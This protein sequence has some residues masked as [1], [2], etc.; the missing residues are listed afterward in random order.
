MR[1][2]GPKSSSSTDCAQERKAEDRLF[3]LL[4]DVKKNRVEVDELRKIELAR[5]SP[6][7]RS[8]LAQMLAAELRGRSLH[9]SPANSTVARPT[10]LC[11][12]P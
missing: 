5:L 4:R 11:W 1:E 3:D 10:R 6:G 2:V 12:E 8:R 9:P 7:V